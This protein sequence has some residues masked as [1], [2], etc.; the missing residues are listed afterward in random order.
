M[1][2]FTYSVSL[3]DFSNFISTLIEKSGNHPVLRLLYVRINKKMQLKNY[4][5]DKKYFST[6][7]S[8]RKSNF[9]CYQ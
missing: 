5:S 4:N 3:C 7:V 1:F 6:I 8:G 9:N 2:N